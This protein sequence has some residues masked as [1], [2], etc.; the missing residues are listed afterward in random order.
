MLNPSNARELILYYHRAADLLGSNDRFNLGRP[1]EAEAYYRKALALAERLAATDPNNMTAK[2]EVAR[3]IGKLG[4][5]LEES[6]AAETLRL[7]QR[8]RQIVASL[9]QGAQRDALQGAIQDSTIWPLAT[10]GRTAEVRQLV[11]AEYWE[12]QLA[13]KPGDPEAL[14]N[15]RDAWEAIAYCERRDTRVSIGY[16]RKALSYADRA[17]Q[18]Q[19]ASLS[20]TRIHLEVLEYMAAELE[21][22]GG[23]AAEVKALRQRVVD[24]WIGLDR[25][26]PGSAYIQRRLRQAKAGV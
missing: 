24:L 22:A 23:A 25:L 5:V 20:R 6:N 2:T 12:A 4:M 16:Y 1:A 3:S 26:Y 8:A 21:K 17:A 19:P 15:L 9:P 14:D 11:Q 10:L 13:K 7:Y 18:T